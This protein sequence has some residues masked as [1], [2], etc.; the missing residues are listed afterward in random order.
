MNSKI[1]CTIVLSTVLLS[2]A[3]NAIAEDVYVVD[4]YPEQRGMRRGVV[5]VYEH[6]QFIPGH[7]IEESIPVWK[8]DPEQ[9]QRV[10]VDYQLTRVWIPP[11]TEYWITRS[12]QPTD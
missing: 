12:W 7:W 3:I 5:T 4:R 9:K 8:W 6:A 2:L 10:I 11:H 1:L